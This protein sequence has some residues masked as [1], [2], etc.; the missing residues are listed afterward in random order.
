M[1][2]FW[3]RKKDLPVAV[4]FLCFLLFQSNDS[5]NNK[6]EREREKLCHIRRKWVLFSLV[7]VLI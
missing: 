4:N 1:G 2:V 5:T 7:G 3:M 6:Q